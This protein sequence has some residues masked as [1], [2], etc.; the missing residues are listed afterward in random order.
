MH[1][2]P[3]L[4]E[5]AKRGSVGSGGRSPRRG[6]KGSAPRVCG[7]AHAP[8]PPH[9]RR[10]VVGAERLPTPPL[11]RDRQRS[12]VP[13]YRVA[14]KLVARSDVGRRRLRREA[15][16]V[17]GLL[18]FAV[19]RDAPRARM[20]RCV[21]AAVPR[22]PQ[23]GGMKTP[24]VRE[25]LT[26]RVPPTLHRSLRDV[27]VENGRSLNAGIVQRLKRSFEGVALSDNDKPPSSTPAQRPVREEK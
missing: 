1:S 7:S 21:M 14:Q 24:L 11:R 2:G 3:P 20:P 23:H 5:T 13:A 9:F 22:G 19:I 4:I 26:L 15:N 10:T 25:K 16:R 17:F 6:G 27:A 12:G 8:R 18:P